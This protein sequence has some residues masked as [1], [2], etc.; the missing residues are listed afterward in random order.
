MGEFYDECVRNSYITA[1][2]N[3]CDTYGDDDCRY[4]PIK[5]TCHMCDGQ[6]SNL[7]TKTLEKCDDI[8]KAYISNRVNIINDDNINHPTYYTKG[9]IEVWDF[10]KDKNLNY[11]RGCAIKYICR[12][13]LK[14]ENKTIEDLKKAINYLN[15][16]IEHLEKEKEN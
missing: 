7:D 8:C 3:F 4:C 2:C 1:L 16:E 12:A 9:E 13:G 11:D 5:K 15:H 10:I 14:D 6:W